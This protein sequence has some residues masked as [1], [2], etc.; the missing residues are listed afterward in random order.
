IEK[1]NPISEI[2]RYT[3]NE[4]LDLYPFTLDVIYIPQKLQKYCGHALPWNYV[5]I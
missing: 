4:T 2:F 1:L 3:T 5:P